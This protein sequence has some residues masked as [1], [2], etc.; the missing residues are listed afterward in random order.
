MDE[1]LNYLAECFIDCQIA[2]EKIIG[3]EYSDFIALA[4]LSKELAFLIDLQM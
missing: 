2:T 4:N 1:E 3:S